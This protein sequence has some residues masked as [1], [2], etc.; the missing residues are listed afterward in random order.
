MITR[1]HDDGTVRSEAL[2]SPCERYR[3]ALT[4]VWAPDAPRL[5][6][7][8][9]NPSKATETQNDPTIARCQERA[10]RLGHGAL[11]VVNLFAW[12]ETDPKALRAA[13]AP[14]GP[15]NDAVLRDA[16]AWGDMILAGWGFHGA[17]MGRDAEVATLLRG[18][19][20]PLHVLGLTKAGQPRH[21]LYIS[22][23]TVP[24]AWQG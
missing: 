19:G 16:C 6:F 5:V 14:I 13:G 21:P 11:R 8:M 2:Y 4:R 24:L 3:Y 10:R 18:T 1:R 22:Y 12:R 17:H 7:V 15:E 20:R 23:D 9:L